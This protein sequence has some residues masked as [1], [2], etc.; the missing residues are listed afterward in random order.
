M[1]TTFLSESRQVLFNLR[2]SQERR[3]DANVQLSSGLR[4]TKPSDSPSDAAAVVRTSTDL[5]VLEQ[6]RTNLDQVQAELRAVDGSLFQAVTVVTRALSLATQGASDT[7]DATGRAII[8]SEIDGIFRH[9][10]QL[11]NTNHSG[12]FLFAGA[13]VETTPFVIDENSSDG[14]IYQGDDSSRAVNFPDGRPAQISLPGNAVFARPDLYT[15]SGRTPET[16]GA[17]VPNPPIGLGIA[18]SGDVDAVISTDLAGFFVAS[19]APSAPSGG[20]TI[21]VTFTSSDGAIAETITTPALAGG[22]NTAQIAT[23]LNTEIANNSQLAGNLTFSDNGSGNLRLVQSDTLGVGFT[24][25]SSATGGLT[26]GLEPGGTVG[27]LS[28]AEI[29]A[30]LNARVAANP[31]LTAANITFTAVNGELQVDGD[32][33]FSFTAIDFDRGTGFRSGLAG[34]HLVGG[35]RSANVFGA[36]HQLIQDLN[37]N[38]QPGIVQGVESLRRA[39][40]HLSVSQ[41][42]YGG[43][44]R[45][46]DVTLAN[47]SELNVVNRER[48]SR[49]RDTDVLEAIE[50]L[51][52]NT[53]A[54]QFALQV[55]ARQQ[56]TLLDL[57]A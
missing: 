16:P 6:F 48:L 55:A 17:S 37:G 49:H 54:E 19:S 14:V 24:F 18:F 51:I 53:S 36:L 57:L 39:V 27:G 42:F 30:A 22:E 34:T 2:Q 1:R 15:G 41:G 23:L 56:P 47:L 26:T 25:T 44:L 5:K 46:V 43:T 3:H 4:V 21:S 45:Q 8:A 28:A 52:T 9:L 12:R 20:E 38:N 7:Q 32:V 29:A 31:Q 11:A 40:D 50:K 33:D 10:V 13:A 35:T